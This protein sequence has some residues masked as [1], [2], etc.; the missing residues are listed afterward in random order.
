MRGTVVYLSVCPS[1]LM[2]SSASS[3]LCS[4]WF[5]ISMK[6]ALL[7]QRDCMSLSLAMHD[8]RDGSFSARSAFLVFR[9]LS[10]WVLFVLCMFVEFCWACDGSFCISISWFSLY[11][12]G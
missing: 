8:V 4:S 6:I 7:L 2:L 5:F 11:L 12:F 9:S 1:Q 10:L 3:K